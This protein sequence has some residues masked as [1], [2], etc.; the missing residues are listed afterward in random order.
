[1]NLEVKNDVFPDQISQVSQVSGATKQEEGTKKD[2]FAFADPFAKKN[3]ILRERLTNLSKKDFVIL[4]L[5][6]L[7]IWH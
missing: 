3:G 7:R 1:M 4:Y 6:S 5:S 2:L